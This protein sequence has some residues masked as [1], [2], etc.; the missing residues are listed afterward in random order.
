[1]WFKKLTW[2]EPIDVIRHLN[3]DIWAAIKYLLRVWKKKEE[4]M[5]DVDK[6]IEDLEKAKFYID[7]Y[8]NNVLKNNPYDDKKIQARIEKSVKEISEYLP[9]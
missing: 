7:D 3:F 4:W 6:A 5:S 1:M 2:I 9:E 8:I